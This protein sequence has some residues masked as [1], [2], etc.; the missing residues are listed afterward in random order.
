MKGLT[1]LS[2]TVIENNVRL[3]AA[4]IAAMFF[5]IWCEESLGWAY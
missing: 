4:T 1:I 5:E 2:A 3:R